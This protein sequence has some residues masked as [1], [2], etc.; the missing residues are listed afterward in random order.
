MF[1]DGVVRQNGRGFLQCNT[2]ADC[3][4]IGAGNCSISHNRACFDDTI[5][6]EGSA[7]MFTADLSALFCIPPTNSAAVNN[8]SGL[9]GAGAVTLSTE[10]TALCASDETVAW[11]PPGGSNCP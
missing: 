3:A 6:I 2:V 11:E 9:P 10:L 8:S 1:C 5:G 7:T 4:A